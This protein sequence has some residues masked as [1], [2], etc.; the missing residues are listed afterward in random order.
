MRTHRWPYTPCCGRYCLR[1]FCD[2][3]CQNQNKSKL[4]QPS[5]VEYLGSDF[6]TRQVGFVF[7]RYHDEMVL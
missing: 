7:V 6:E 1:W 2:F 4:Q 5:R 3:G